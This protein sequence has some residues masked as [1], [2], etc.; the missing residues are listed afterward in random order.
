M[1]YIALAG[2][3]QRIGNNSSE[4]I[5]AILVTA[6]NELDADTKARGIAKLLGLNIEN[7]HTGFTVYQV[8]DENESLESFMIA[9][10]RLVKDEAAQR[11]RVRL[12]ATEHQ[13][14]KVGDRV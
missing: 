9:K 10:E 2:N 5:R 1:R 8:I 12:A 13:K 4:F 6:T 7:N 14:A 11:E 3:E